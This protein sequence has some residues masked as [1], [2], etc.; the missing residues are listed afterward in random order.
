M[1]TKPKQEKPSKNS[2]FK[3]SED[4]TEESIFNSLQ[5]IFLR[6]SLDKKQE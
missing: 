3:K 2:E 6:Q 1:V 4:P 5:R